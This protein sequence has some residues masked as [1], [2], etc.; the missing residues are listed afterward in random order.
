VSERISALEEAVEAMH[1]CR[2]THFDTVPFTEIMGTRIV[3]EGVV[4][5]FKLDG[6]PEAKFCYA[7]RYKD[8]EE[9]KYITVLKIPPVTSAQTAVQAAIASRQQK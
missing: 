4:E 6:H 7:W 9:I 5:V 2:A 8:E 3:W 1:K